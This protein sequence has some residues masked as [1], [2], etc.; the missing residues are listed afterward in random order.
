[1]SLENFN[2]SFAKKKIACYFLDSE[3]P[4]KAYI[5]ID[6]HYLWTEK[7][8]QSLIANVIKLSKLDLDVVELLLVTRQSLQHISSSSECAQE[9]YKGNLKISNRLA[10]PLSGIHLNTISQS[11]RSYI[12]KFLNQISQT[13]TTY[14]RSI[15]STTNLLRI[16]LNPKTLSSLH[17][18]K[19]A[20]PL[21]D[22]IFFTKNSA[23][24]RSIIP[25]KFI[26]SN[27]EKSYKDILKNLD[28][29]P[30][31]N[32]TNIPDQSNGVLLQKFPRENV[33]LSDG[34][35]RLSYLEER[36]PNVSPY[37][38]LMA[39]EINGEINNS[40]L[41]K[42]V[43]GL[44]KRHESLRTGADQTKQQ[45]IIFNQDIANSWHLNCL[46]TMPT[47]IK[48]FCKEF[49]QQ[50]FDLTKPPLIRAVL[51]PISQAKNSKRYY[52]LFVIHHSVFDGY[53]QTIFLKELSTLYEI[54]V[55]N[56]AWDF[57]SKLPETSIQFA[58]YSQW[59]NKVTQVKAPAQLE[60]WKEELKDFEILNFPTDFIRPQQKTFAGDRIPLVIPPNIKIALS[61]LA[62]KSSVSL[63]TCLLA[64]FQT[65]LHKYTLQDDICSGTMTANRKKHSKIREK[66]QDL[67][68]FVAN[69]IAIRTKF[70]E[71]LTVA[72]LIDKIKNTIQK[73]IH[74]NSDIPFGEVVKAIKPTLDTSRN[75]IFETLFVFQDRDY[76]N[77]QLK[78]TSVT[79]IECG[80]GSSPFDFTLEL[81]E[82][83]KNT[84]IGF[85]D[86]NSSLFSAET[87]QRMAL[88]FI[89]L[90][91]DFSLNPDK[92]ITDLNS[93]SP[94][95]RKIINLLME[96][97]SEKQIYLPMHKVI[98]QVVE[99]NPGRPAVIFENMPAC[100]YRELD[101]F[102]NQLAHFLIDKH[103]VKPG[104]MI[105]ICLKRSVELVATILAAW[106]AGAVVFF[107]ETNVDGI[108]KN[109]LIKIAHKLVTIDPYKIIAHRDTQNLISKNFAE[110]IITIEDY[111]LNHY[112]KNVNNAAFKRPPQVN[113]SAD[114]LAMIAFT[115]GSSSP[116]AIPKPIKIKH[117][118][119]HN[120][121][122]F[123]QKHGE[124]FGIIPGTTSFL[125]LRMTFD[126]GI[127]EMF[128]QTLGHGSTLCIN[129]ENNQFDPSKLKALFAKHNI[130][131][132]EFTPT[133][134]SGLKPEDFP[135]LTH[136]FVVGE[137][138]S[139]SLI[140]PWIRAEKTVINGYGPTETTIGVT[141]Y[142]CDLD[143]PIYIGKPITG[144][145][146]YV[147]DKHLKPVGFGRYGELYVSGVGIAEGYLNLPKETEEAFVKD[148][149]YP[150]IMYKTGD[151]VRLA[152]NGNLEFKSRINSSRQTKR[153]GERIE[154][155]EI[156]RVLAKHPN[157]K[158]VIVIA[159]TTN[160]NLIAA[161]I[162][163]KDG[164]KI[165]YSNIRSF[166]LENGLST[167]KIPSVVLNLKSLP[168]TTN[169]KLN[170]KLLS[171]YAI[172]YK[173]SQVNVKPSTDTE[174]K[175][176]TVWQ[177]M[178]AGENF[179][180]EDYFGEVG[181]SSL[182][183]FFLLNN[184]NEIF[185]KNTPTQISLADF[186]NNDFTIKELAKI[187]DDKLISVQKATITII[188]PPEDDENPYN[189]SNIQ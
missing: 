34:Q 187:V 141:L 15:Y 71:N 108:S 49:T 160:Q 177:N 143:T 25:F 42:C 98:E 151:L 101:T 11:I 52:L 122:T 6:Y 131:V 121:I 166:L 125:A 27:K 82:S 76:Q 75:P 38:W 77:L 70:D 33:P 144:T 139:K 115:S 39:F 162:I 182:E 41:E 189:Y 4:K 31:K 105:G 134:L 53:S 68:G 152:S 26:S 185:F 28:F 113:I 56:P 180:I 29:E 79:P 109:D 85:F 65:F 157:I 59:L 119:L 128:C 165:E 110:K 172:Q 183:I 156:E 19:I 62:R 164:N 102:A 138:F 48:S 46:G 120:W 178:F 9:Y 40:I 147:L 154:L 118:G 153:K 123:Y 137:G 158:T 97:P 84:L 24:K 168:P 16:F 173:L 99:K 106:K 129:S 135:T 107:L 91:E 159:I 149:F 174:R 188:T 47:D 146:T 58:D 67:I 23:M 136:V 61:E 100:S 163:S 130:K 148:P 117:A 112:T 90:L 36:N 86:Y 20:L 155:D 87:V 116:D 184:L 57:T 17:P 72:T 83:D 170:I 150:G 181:G 94:A 30:E 140:E 45:Q 132:A 92:K 54:A 161:F 96:N 5:V 167:V 145:R 7:K 74:E 142:V 88:N 103:K 21:N 111:Y 171:E 55:K 2:N 179:G 175:I 89:T 78:D 176:Y 32:P 63:F 81:R 37:N 114:D 95:E 169:G 35:L 22:D 133:I 93:I 66:L 8:I 64:A 73:T 12:Q 10:I 43:R 126:G 186:K 18:K 60:F 14:I 13:I 44:I 50:K 80:W 69:S 104:D 124:K 51:A 127:C 3:N 1:M